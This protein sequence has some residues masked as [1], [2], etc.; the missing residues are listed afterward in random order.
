MY[1]HVGVGLVGV[2]WLTSW[3]IYI[4]QSLAVDMTRHFENHKPDWLL[5]YNYYSFSHVSPALLVFDDAIYKMIGP[6]QPKLRYSKCIL[7]GAQTILESS[8]ATYCTADK[9]QVTQIHINKISIYQTK[10]TKCD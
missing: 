4:K 5:L 9:F 1:Q 6:K 2:T 10:C 3:K 8:L 7:V